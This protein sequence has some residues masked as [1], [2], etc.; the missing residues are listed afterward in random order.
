LPRTYYRSVAKVIDVP[1]QLAVGEDFRYPEVTGP[2]QLGGAFV[3]WYVEKVHRAA[4]YDPQVAE[5]F[6]SVLHLLIRPSALF[7]PTIIARVLFGGARA[8]A[9]ATAS[10][11]AAPRGRAKAQG[12]S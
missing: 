6:Y 11:P 2:R 3:N 4:S 8:E 12:S 7:T 5:C 9:Q 1:W 10:I